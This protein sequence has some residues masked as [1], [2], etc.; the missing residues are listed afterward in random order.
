M[1]CTN[2]LLSEH[3]VDM[4]LQ[5]LHSLGDVVDNTIKDYNCNI[6]L[7]DAIED[8]IDWLCDGQSHSV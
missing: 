6:Q 3:E 8:I 4:L 2:V 5:K 1:S 7:H